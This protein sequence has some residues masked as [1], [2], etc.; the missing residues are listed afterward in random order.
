[1][2]LVRG[3]HSFDPH[4]ATKAVVVTLHHTGHDVLA[5]A[6]YPAGKMSNRMH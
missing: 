2:H 5:V 4:R 1:V 6:A 3:L